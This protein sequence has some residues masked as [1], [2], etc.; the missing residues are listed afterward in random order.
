MDV[1]TNGCYKQNRILMITVGIWPDSP[2]IVKL[3]ARSVILTILCS[4]L[5]PQ[6]A[7]LNH[8]DRH[9]NDLISVLIIQLVILTVVLK[10]CYIG[11]NM[12]MVQ[13]GMVR[14]QED[15][16][17]LKETPAIDQIRRYAK[18]G[19]LISRIYIIF[20]FCAT[21]Q[22]FFVMPLKPMILDA[23]WPSNES[24]PRTYAFDADYSI[25][26]IYENDYYWALLHT[27]IIG[28]TL[29][30]GIVAIDTFILIIV[31]HCCGL[32]DAVGYILQGLRKES[33]SLRRNKIIRDAIFVHNRALSLADLIESSFTM[34]FAFVVLINMILISMTA[35]E[36]VLKVDDPGEL[37]RF[38]LFIIGQIAHLFC[39]SLPGQELLDHSSRVFTDIY[40]SNWSEIADKEQKLLLFMLMRSMK[41]SYMTA[42]KFYTLHIENFK[43]VLRTSM[44]YFTVFLSIR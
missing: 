14:M 23:I 24:R 3:F 31:E 22:V 40:N 20:F 6:Y 1:F 32:F 33:C 39:T 17:I 21:T 18:R 27:L 35:F 15:W 43:N 7:F 26:S 13:N 12:K 42:G 41:P 8:P 10:I 29:V 9:L 34:M 16:V 2:L 5:P 19:Y 36:T 37:V 25:F 30:E 4:L 38:V 44:S 11:F 28:L